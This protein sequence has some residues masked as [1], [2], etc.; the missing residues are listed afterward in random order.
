MFVYYFSDEKALYEVF[1]NNLTAVKELPVRNPLF[2]LKKRILI[3]GKEY[4]FHIKK[5][6]PP[7]KEKEIVK[8][9]SFDIEDAVPIT[10]P[11]YV[12]RISE[13]KETYCEVDLFAWQ[14]DT[15]SEIREKFPYTHII[16]EDL[17]FYSPEPAIFVLPKNQR[18]YLVATSKEG[19]IASHIISPQPEEFN[20]FLKALGR[21]ADSLKRI[22]CYGL[23]REE[24][25]R[26]LPEHFRPYLVIKKSLQED[27]PLFLQKIKLRDFKLK[28]PLETDRILLTSARVFIYILIAIF[29]NLYFTYHSYNSA[30]QDT[31]KKINQFDTELKSF[32]EI[33]RKQTSRALELRQLKQELTKKLDEGVTDLFSILDGIAGCLPDESYITTFEL[34]EKNL[35]MYVYT[36]DVFEVMEKLR[37][38]QFVKSV[39]LASPPSHDK[40]K[41]TYSFR[42]EVTL[43]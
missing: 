24:V 12:F 16:P 33:S 23:E 22:V 19:F 41:K 6:Y 34:K 15:V 1:K 4:F 42:V 8:A 30:I 14:S 20:L 21:Y 40:A 38:L 18:I 37:K 31:R 35:S 43:R 9:L 32:E 3:L 5:K 29:L 7:L 11:Q 25:Y 28:K 39:K 13:R 17:I 2:Y 26:F 10:N 27:L 36:K